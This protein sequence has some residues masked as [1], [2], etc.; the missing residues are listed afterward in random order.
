[1]EAREREAGR[2]PRELHRRAQ[3]RLARAARRRACTRHRCLRRRFHRNARHRQAAILELGGDDA[4]GADRLAFD[5]ARLVE[6]REA[7]AAPQVVKEIDVAGEQVGERDRDRI[8]EPDRVRGGEERAGDFA[9]RQREPH[10]FARRLVAR[11]EG[12]VRTLDREDVAGRGHEAQRLEVALARRRPRAPVVPAS[13][14]RAPAREGRCAGTPS[15]RDRRRRRARAG[16]RSCRRAGCAPRASTATR[17]RSTLRAAEREAH[18]TMVRIGVAS[19][20]VSGARPNAATP[21]RPRTSDRHPVA[22]PEAP[23]LAATG[24]EPAAA[25]EFEVC[26]FGRH[27]WSRGLPATGG[28]EF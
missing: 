3:E 1:M 5:V 7:I 28:R 13:A 11:E 19:S 24:R 18:V 20:D 27:C 12:V 4:A 10:C 25:L 14:D 9:G 15:R 16:C 8:R 17:R 26:L 6:H 21:V 22:R 2:H 23:A